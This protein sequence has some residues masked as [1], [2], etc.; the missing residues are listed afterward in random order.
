MYEKSSSESWQWFENYLTYSNAVLPEALFLGHKVLKD[1][2][3][4][5]IA[6]KTLDFLISKSFMNGIY[7]P[8]GQDGW[9]HKDGERKLYD[10]QPEDVLAMIGALKA[11]FEATG[12]IMY[13]RL[14][15]KAFSWFLGDNTSTQMVYDPVTGGCYDGLAETSINLNQGAESTI[16]YLLSRLSFSE[17]N[18]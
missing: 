6:K 7:V 10:Q 13:D 11:A 1:T 2:R 17:D 15:Y 9:C 12:N 14:R 4:L 5:D 18:R 16:S 8:I 3:L